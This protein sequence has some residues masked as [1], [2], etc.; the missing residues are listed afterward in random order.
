MEHNESFTEA[1]ARIEGAMLASRQHG[2]VTVV[3]AVADLDTV[4][5]HI[6]GLE[7]QLEAVIRDREGLK[8][9][10]VSLSTANAARAAD[11]EDRQR[12]EL[13]AEGGR[14]RPPCRDGRAGVL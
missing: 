9:W 8:D 3:V 2:F 4:R 12:R 14:G 11:A 13:R 7:D 10:T 1:M 5:E 6:R